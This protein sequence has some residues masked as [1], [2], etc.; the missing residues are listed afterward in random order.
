VFNGA[1]AVALA[2]GKGLA[3]AV[4]FANA[5]AAI[6]VTRDGAQPASPYRAEILALLDATTRFDAA[7]D[8]TQPTLSAE[9]A[10]R[11]A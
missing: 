10:E 9:R 3:D 8:T 6:S 1:M 2:E 5:A 7:D 11:R 4:R